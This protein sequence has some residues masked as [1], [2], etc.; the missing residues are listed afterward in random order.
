MNRRQMESYCQ[1]QRDIQDGEYLNREQ[2]DED[3]QEAIEELCFEIEKVVQSGNEIDLFPIAKRT[4]SEFFFS[5]ETNSD[6][7]IRA[8]QNG[9]KTK[10]TY[11]IEKVTSE[12]ILELAEQL[13]PA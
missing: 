3:R 5:D 12:M 6:K 7:V 8:I 2:A 13:I 4:L 11:E 1:Y 9:L 10:T